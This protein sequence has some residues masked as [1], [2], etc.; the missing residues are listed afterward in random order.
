MKL[1]QPREISNADDR[2]KECESILALW[3]ANLHC[4]E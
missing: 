2:F 3:L 4:T 1:K